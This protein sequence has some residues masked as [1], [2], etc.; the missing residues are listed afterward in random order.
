MNE[1]KIKHCDVCGF[2]IECPK[3]GNN[4]CNGHMDLIKNIQE[5]LQK[6]EI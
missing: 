5:Y 6:S 1:I 3:C 2:T 4:S